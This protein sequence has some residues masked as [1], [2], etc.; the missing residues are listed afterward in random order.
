MREAKRASPRTREERCEEGAG[1]AQS[2]GAN[3]PATGSDLTL[4]V[5]AP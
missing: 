3:S 4:V 2:M 1:A 5:L